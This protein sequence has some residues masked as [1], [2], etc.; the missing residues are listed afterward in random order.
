MARGIE[1]VSRVDR[2]IVGSDWTTGKELKK[3]LQEMEQARAARD[4]KQV[5]D[6]VTVKHGSQMSLNRL[7]G[8]ETSF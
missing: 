4:Q 2:Q 8:I 3:C 5:G 1:T 7:P 6:W